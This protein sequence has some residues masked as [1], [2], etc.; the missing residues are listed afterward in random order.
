MGG[1]ERAI[2][3]ALLAS[4]I[5]SGTAAAE[6]RAATSD[7]QGAGDP[8]DSAIEALELR[9]YAAWKAKDA[10]F[11]PAFLSERFIG[12]GSSGRLD[13]ATAAR[14]LRGGACAVVQVTG[15]QVSWLTPAAAVITH[16]TSVDGPCVGNA[17]PGARWTATGYVLEGRRWKAAF[18]AEAPIVDPSQPKAS[19]SVAL[20][21]VGLTKRDAQTQALLDQEQALW[22]AWKDRDAR[23]LDALLPPSI[24]FINIFGM[25]LAT[26]TEALK[27][28][29]GEGCDVKGFD[30]GDAR[31]TMFT[32]DFGILTLYATADGS[33][34]GQKVAPVWTSSFYVKRGKAWVWSFGINI[35]ARATTG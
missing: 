26:R 25:H 28:W 19:P 11:W 31:A 8:R 4:V 34:Y 33:C 2:L 30:L 14:E 24:Q 17:A 10:G 32:P 3:G 6:P 21:P 9:S 18:R 29:S 22:S 5:A 23:R 16:K 35:P 15:A 13:K 20:A 7:A 12:W 1:A 27:N